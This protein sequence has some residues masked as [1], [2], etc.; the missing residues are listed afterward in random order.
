MQEENQNMNNSSNAID[1]LSG[2]DDDIVVTNK[3]SKPSLMLDTFSEKD[4]L[5]YLEKRARNNRAVRKSRS[6]RKDKYDTVS[7]N[8]LFLASH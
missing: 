5:D 3:F 2:T 8:K 6:K 4:R 7:T 1:A